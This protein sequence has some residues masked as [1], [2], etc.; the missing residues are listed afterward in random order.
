MKSRLNHLLQYCLIVFLFYIFKYTS[1]FEAV[2]NGQT[3]IVRL[4]IANGADVSKEGM[5]R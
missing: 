2:R 4:L 3:D 1:L 5:V